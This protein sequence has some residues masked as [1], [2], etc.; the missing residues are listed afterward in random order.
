MNR[1]LEIVITEL[2]VITQLRKVAAVLAWDQETYMP[3]G[4]AQ[5]RSEQISLVLSLAHAR[6]TSDTFRQSLATLVDLDG[7]AIDRDG[8]VESIL[9]GRGHT[10]IPLSG[11]TN[12]MHLLEGRDWPAFDPD[13]ARALLA[14]AGYPDGFSITLTPSIRGAAAEVE[15]CEIIAQMWN[16]I[17]LDVNFQRIPYGTLRPQL[18]GRTYQGATCHA[19]S[20]LSTPARGYGS[21]L[22][23]NPF[24]RGLEHPWQEAKMLLAQKEVDPVKRNALEKEIGIF[25]LDNALTDLTYYTMDAVWP[26]GPRLEP[27]GEF[28][29]TTDVRQ[30]NGY[31]FIQ[32]RK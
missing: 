14:E 11:Y 3:S 27:W 15:S 26:V 23:E 10:E 16:D 31:E 7:G 21:Y 13:K 25:L 2:E 17:G 20:P 9:G 1:K 4:S 8:L 32:H 18:V 24:N 29:K 28:V 30:I 22:S 5:A 12:F 19:G 6:F